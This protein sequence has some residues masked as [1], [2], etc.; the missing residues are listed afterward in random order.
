MITPGSYKLFSLGDSAVTIDFGNL[1][2]VS[3]NEKVID[4]FEYLRKNPLK[5]MTE[6]VP[7]Y[8]SLTICYDV[9]LPGSV[10][11]E[12]NSALDFIKK[13]ISQ[14]LQDFVPGSTAPKRQPIRIPVCYENEFAPDLEWIAEQKN[15]AANDV[16]QTHVTGRYRV[17]MI[18]FLPGFAYMGE[19][20]E[21]IAIPRKTRPR[22]NVEKGSVGI[23]G[24][25]T[26][27]YP[28]AS[29]GGWQIIGRTPL[30]LFD[31]TKESPVLLEPG[32]EIEFYSISEEE[33][34]NFKQ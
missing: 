9:F 1:I 20:D 27:I 22:Q 29:P 6:V 31:A 13:E 4:L 23:A 5:G 17:Y 26:G 10:N 3:V 21:Q 7:A 33:F 28:L 12:G 11:N 14:L 2:D 34:F 30:K 18:G 24:R 15:L 19:V 16:I 8:S 25:Q 32:D